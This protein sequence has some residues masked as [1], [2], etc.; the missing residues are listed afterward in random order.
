LVNLYRAGSDEACISG[1]L[2]SGSALLVKG[3][4]Q[5]SYV[6]A[7]DQVTIDCPD[8]SQVHAS[9]QQLTTFNACRGVNCPN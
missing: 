3:K 5:L 8:G 6:G 1:G 4:Q 2:N 9:G 7:G